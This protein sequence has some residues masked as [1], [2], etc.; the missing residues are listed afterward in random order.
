[1]ASPSRTQGGGLGRLDGVGF[2]L[3]VVVARTEIRADEWAGAQKGDVVVV[4]ELW[5][6]PHDGGWQGE[7]RLRLPWGKPRWMATLTDPGTLEV[8][9]WIA[10]EEEGNTMDDTE[11][12]HV[13]QPEELLA[14]LPL[15]LSVELG[16][17]VLS[18]KQA[19]E[20]GPGQTLLLER[21]PGDPVELRAG[22][23][24]LA[25][26]ELVEVEGE[27]GVRLQRI[28]PEP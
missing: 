12:G 10:P 17:I 25:R 6:R 14:E 28:Y 26:G 18:A 27:L 1:L 22:P 7:A 24:L 16:R 11:P 19:L 13:A 21:R 4:D 15:S 8:T 9:S 2:A 20:L 5:A 23:K 3:H